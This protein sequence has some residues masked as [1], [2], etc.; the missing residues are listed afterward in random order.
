MIDYTESLRLLCSVMSVSGYELNGLDIIKNSFGEYFDEIYSDSSRNIILKKKSTRANPKKIMLDAHFDEVGMMVSGV[1][2]EGFLRV[3]SVGGLDRNLLPSAEVMVYGKETLY[4]VIISDA[5]HLP[6]KKKD[7]PPEWSEILVDIGY[8]KEE[9]E[10]LAPIGTPIKYYYE[11]DTLLNNRITGRGF[12][13]KACGA[14]LIAATMRTPAEKLAFDVYITLSSGE[15]IGRG[16]AARAAWSIDP[17]YAI[18][19]DVNFALTPGV[20]PDEGGKLGDGP[21]VSLSAVTDRKLTKKILWVAEKNDIH[22]TTVV[23]STS[24]GTNAS[25]VFF[26]GEGV[27]TAVVSLPLAGMHSYNELL[28]LDDAESF[29]SLISAVISCEDL[30]N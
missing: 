21:M 16:G 29:I 1:T 6:P 11:G 17:D 4:G 20:S 18:V 7:S 14:A 26:V 19:T 24:T 8:P 30:A 23:E 12:D 9:A 3:V 25:C 27:P 15:E 5:D 10:I 22:V 28:Q 13:D 2:G